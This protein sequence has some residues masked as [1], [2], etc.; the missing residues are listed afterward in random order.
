MGDFSLSGGV[1]V[2]GFISP[3][4]INDTYPVIDPLYG[5]DGFR[6]VNLISEL[7]A[8]P[9][10]RRR[11]GMVVGVSG[12]TTYYKLNS[13]PWNYTI[14]DWS[15]FSS[16]GGSSGGTVSGDYLP[17]SGGTVTGVTYFQ[18]TSPS[19]EYV[20]FF[21]GSGDGAKLGI[22]VSGDI[23]DG[24]TN[25]ILNSG[26]TGYAKLTITASEIVNNIVNSN[27]TS[28]MPDAFKLDTNGDATIGGI[29][30]LTTAPNIENTNDHFL[31]RNQITNVIEVRELQT[32]PTV[33]GFTFNQSTYDLTIEL[34]TGVDYTQNLSILASDVTITGGTY[35][36]QNGVVTFTNNTG[37]TFSVT[38]FSTN[39]TDIYTTGST[40]NPI[41]KVATFNRTDNNTYTLNLSALTTTDV[42]V[43]GGTYSN[44]TTTFTNNTGGTF[45]V[46]GFSTSNATN[47]TGGTVTGAT[48]FTGGLTANTIS[49]TTYFNLPTDIRVTGGTF[50]NNTK[51]LSLSNNTGGTFNVTG[52]TDIYVSGATFTGSTLTLTRSENQSNITATIP[53]LSLSGAMSS[54]TFNIATSGSFSA[55]TYLGL[56]TDIRVTGGTYSSG[57]A[58]FTNNTGGTFTVTGFSTPFT[59]GT[60]TGAT[61][62]TGGLTANT[63]SATTYV[64]LPT[65]IRVTGGTYS[66]GTA[67]FTNN[68]GGTF[69]VT[70]FY[71]GTTDITT[72]GATYSNNT[73]TYTNNTGGTFN[74]LFD[75][76]TGLTVNGNITV[77][78]TSNLNGTIISTNLS[79]STDRL[80]QVSSG[81]TFSASQDIIQ[82]YINSLGAVATLLSTTSN[83]DVNGVYVGSTI[84]GTYQGQKHY[85]SNYF[86][87]AVDDNLWI[88]LIRG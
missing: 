54:M 51:T 61:N 28:I 73:F 72:T 41:T 87:E 5:I 71:T 85:D 44:G 35:N 33:D 64:N 2:F 22:G 65:D 8:I 18:G 20:T 24:I 58:T 56:P 29:L 70:G 9:V 42:F 83:W 76:V 6:N 52:F 84:T 31:T 13:S 79:G 69:N 39:Y 38:G 59:G 66:S 47:F 55:A 57:A 53:T 40:F 80:V 23:N 43:T 46:T 78:G 3:S 16:G 10:L 75:T 88:R 48:N 21:K 26:G 12:G 82:T 11:A 30:N 49:A 32:L 36:P 45:T 34:N 25:D 86:F 19:S 74:V 37:G 68:T 4:S 67:T 7:N 17:L 62:F 27:G 50:N 1:E 77:T 81:G 15:I 63:I 60:V 14:S